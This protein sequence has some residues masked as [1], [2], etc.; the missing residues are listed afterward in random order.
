[1]FSN[2]ISEKVVLS[3]ANNAIYKVNSEL[4]QSFSEETRAGLLFRNRICFLCKRYLDAFLYEGEQ[5]TNDEYNFNDD[6][7][8]EDETYYYDSAKEQVKIFACK[9]TIHIRCLKKHYRRRQEKDFEDYFNKRT[10]KLR[11]PYCHIKS[12][13]IESN[14]KSTKY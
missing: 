10:D 9:H 5:S 14:D 12:F 2:S 11:C 3:N 6:D 1:M 4:F 8:D 13:E 7:D